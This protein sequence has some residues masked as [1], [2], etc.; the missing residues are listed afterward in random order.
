MK[1]NGEHTIHILSECEIILSGILIR[2]S[3]NPDSFEYKNRPTRR[4]AP[5]VPIGMSTIYCKLLLTPNPR[6]C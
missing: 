3:R 1:N 2:V 6:Y 4:E 5:F